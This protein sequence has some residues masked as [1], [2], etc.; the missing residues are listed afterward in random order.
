MTTD[1]PSNTDEPAKA[2]LP[3]NSTPGGAPAPARRAFRFNRRTW[4]IAGIVL[5]LVVVLG[6]GIA[7]VIEHDHWGRHGVDLRRVGPGGRTPGLA[8]RDCCLWR[9]AGQGQRGFR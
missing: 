2:D 4:L 6:G 3:V 8:G 5:V 9:N 1:T 7:A